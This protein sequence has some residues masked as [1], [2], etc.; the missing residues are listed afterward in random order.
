[1]LLHGICLMCLSALHCRYQM[2]HQVESELLAVAAGD[3]CSAALSS[4]LTEL[5]ATEK[6]LSC[7]RLAEGEYV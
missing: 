2:V 5:G 4:A 1:M 7:V 3:A 6:G